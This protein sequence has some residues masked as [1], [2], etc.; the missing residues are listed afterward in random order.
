V[1]DAPVVPDDTAQVS[2]VEALGIDLPDRPEEA[3]ELLA[4]HVVEARS[5]A[6][7]YLGDLKRIAAD[8]ENYRKRADRDRADMVASASRRVATALLP[9]LDSLDAA[10]A[11]MDT[12]GE[13]RLRAGLLS[14]R[15]Q[16][17][18]TLAAE[19]VAPIVIERGQPFDPNLHDAV[20]GGGDGHLVI[21]AE[22]RRGYTMHDR[23]L[24]P[25]MVE[26]AAEDL[27]EGTSA[28]GPEE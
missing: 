8:F 20:R 28:D 12:A 1:S 2:A 18:D 13:E 16:L 14:T 27:S 26:V 10:A 21:T 5:T 17:L 4:A 6:D 3:M 15:E 22:L 19:G 24:R 25:A 9:V 11:T 23:L 7:S